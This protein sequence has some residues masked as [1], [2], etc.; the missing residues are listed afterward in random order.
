MYK[1]ETWTS[2]Q[3]DDLNQ[4]KENGNTDTLIEICKKV[5]PQHIAINV[6]VLFIS[7]DGVCRIKIQ[8]KI[9]EYIWLPYYMCLSSLSPHVFDPAV[10]VSKE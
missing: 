1:L 3:L 6:D 5:I 4:I 2:A 9:T 7:C 10:R 8:S